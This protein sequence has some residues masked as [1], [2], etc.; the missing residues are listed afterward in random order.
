MVIPKIPDSPG[1]ITIEWEDLLQKAQLI[2]TE[3]FRDYLKER[4][5][6]LGA[7][8]SLTSTNFN[9][10]TRQM[11]YSRRHLGTNSQGNTTRTEEKETQAAGNINKQQSY[12]S[13][14]K[15]HNN[16]R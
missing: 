13:G 9:Q 11:K 6:R 12:Q 4:A 8:H 14:Q 7:E 3:K 15:K 1:T 2:L 16:S 10:P 5:K